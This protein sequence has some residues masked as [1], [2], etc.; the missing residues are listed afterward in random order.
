MAQI[1]LLQQQQKANRDYIQTI[2]SIVVRVLALGLVAVL[3]YYGYVFYQ[4]H[5]ES[6]AVQKLQANLDQD[7]LNLVNQKDQEELFT[8]QRQLQQLLALVNSHPYWS[9]VLPALAKVTLKSANYLTFTSVNDGSVSMSVSVPDMQTFDKFLQVFDLPEF[10]NNFYDIKVGSISRVQS[11]N[12]TL[13][14][15]DVNM[16]YNAALLQ[17]DATSTPGS[18]Q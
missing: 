13:I 12:Q 8:R 2:T 15:F 17:Y 16:K 1:N 14:N 7:K 9:A 18:T 6:S 3:V 10:N 4:T 11:K 5:T